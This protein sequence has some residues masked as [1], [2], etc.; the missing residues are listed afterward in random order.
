MDVRWHYAKVCK[1]E[2]EFVFCIL[3]GNKHDFPAQ[4]IFENPDFV[5]CPRSNM[6]VDATLAIEFGRKGFAI[7]GKEHAY[8]LVSSF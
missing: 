1:P 2:L 3:Q 5:V 8:K 4:I 7:R 6:I